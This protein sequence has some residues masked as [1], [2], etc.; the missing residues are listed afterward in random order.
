[1][2]TDLVTDIRIDAS[3]PHVWQVLTDLAAYPEWNPFIV[4]ATGQAQ[5]GSH[6]TLRL[7]PVVGR[8]TTVRPT[9]TAARAGEELRWLGHLGVRGLLDA[10][11]H[12]LLTADGD[13]TRLVQREHFGGLLV[14]LVAGTLERGTLPAFVLMNEA[15]KSRAEQ[16]LS[17]TRG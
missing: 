12:F 1:V 11:H 16:P 4:A 5:V 7:Q 9:V 10:D 2:A 8:A 3:P 17:S 6:L 13:G 15:L 14:P